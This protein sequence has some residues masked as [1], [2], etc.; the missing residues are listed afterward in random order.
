M[1]PSTPP[2]REAA[3]AVVVDAD[4]RVLLLRYDE[5]GVFWA[6]PGGSL[7]KGEDY[8]T[9]TLRE[10]R[11]ELG[12]DEKAIDLGPQL[13]KRS[14]D[15]TDAGSRHA[16]TARRATPRLRHLMRFKR[17]GVWTPSPDQGLERERAVRL[18]SMSVRWRNFAADARSRRRRVP[19][20]GRAGRTTMWR[21]LAPVV[22]PSARLAGQVASTAVHIR[23]RPRQ[24]MRRP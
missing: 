3:R 18:Q 6:T 20:R 1:T 8:A 22:R 10:L 19:R 21:T 11:E 13:A 23:W 24:S 17:N 16:P 5:D 9:A 4:D 15:H 2:L 14:K 12:I 7:E